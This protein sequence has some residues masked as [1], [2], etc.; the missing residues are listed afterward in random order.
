[1]KSFL[2]LIFTTLLIQSCSTMQNEAFNKAYIHPVNGF[3]QVVAVT[4]G[5]IK[6]LYISGQIGE[7]VDWQTQMRSVLA[8]LRKELQAC[9]ADYGDMVKMN[10]YIVGYKEEYLPEFRSIRQEIFGAPDMP[11][12]TLVGVEKLGRGEWLI[13]VEA[14]AVIERK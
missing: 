7:G 4:T 1:M 9:G 5:N 6:T 3:S 8:N 14:I 11:A 12:S 10:W 13:E 2:F